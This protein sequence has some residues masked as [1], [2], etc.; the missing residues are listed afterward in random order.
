D[1]KHKNNL[2]I[3]LNKF[4]VEKLPQNI[5]TNINQ[6]HNESNNDDDENDICDT[7]QSADLESDRNDNSRRNS[8]L[9]YELQQEKEESSSVQKQVCKILLEKLGSEYCSIANLNMWQIRLFIFAKTKYKS[10]ISG[11]TMHYVPTGVGGL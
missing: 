4:L 5:I 3:D 1:H 9:E 7:E 2:K 6:F 11:I 10:I 8:F